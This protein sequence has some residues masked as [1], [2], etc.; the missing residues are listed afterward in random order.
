[1][2]IVIII[3]A[4]S[5]FSCNQKL[6]K[7]KNIPKEKGT[8]SNQILDNQKT[9]YTKIKKYAVGQLYNGNQDFG[10]LRVNYGSGKYVYL[11]KDVEGEGFL[12]DST[13]TVT[14]N[15]ELDE[16]LFRPENYPEYQI[17][18]MDFDVHIIKSDGI[19]SMVLSKREKNKIWKCLDV[20]E[21]EK[22]SDSSEYPTVL[23]NNKVFSYICETDKGHVCY[24]VVMDKINASGKYEKVLKAYKFDLANGKIIEIDLKKEKVECE[25]EGSCE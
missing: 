17:N 8:I 22:T 2:R 1:M 18:M 13:V 20:I 6:E 11:E 15:I 10:G 24:A 3:F 5:L 7:V 23:G 16:I 25:P 14:K 21:V 19:L 9:I 4:F 12:I